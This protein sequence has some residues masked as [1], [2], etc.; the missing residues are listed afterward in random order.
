MGCEVSG[1]GGCGFGVVLLGAGSGG[2]EEVSDLCPG[3]LLVAGLGDGLGDALL[4]FGGGEADE[5]VDAVVANLMV[6]L[7]TSGQPMPD[8]PSERERSWNWNNPFL[9]Y[10]SKPKSPFVNLGAQYHAEANILG[11]AVNE[12]FV[13][14]DNTGWIRMFAIDR[15]GTICNI[16]G[17]DRSATLKSFTIAYPGFLLS[18]V[19]LQIGEGNSPKEVRLGSAQD[20]WVG[21]AG[22]YCWLR[23]GK[24]SGVPLQACLD[25]KGTL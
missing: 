7:S 12:N 24:S 17:G 4:D 18:N 19:G 5:K 10:D 6:F 23:G 9:S 21:Q 15:T 14:K 22:Q 8:D 20:A 11:V 25:S 3:V 13:R 1:W 2:A 16:C